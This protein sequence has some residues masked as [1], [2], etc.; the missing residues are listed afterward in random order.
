[1]YDTSFFDCGEAEGSL[2][3]SILITVVVVTKFV[4]F[5]A[6]NGLLAALKGNLLE[7][8]ILFKEQI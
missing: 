1:M 3:F 7:D 8:P 6:S 5:M 4:G 2:A